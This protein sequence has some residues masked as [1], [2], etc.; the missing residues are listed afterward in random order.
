MKQRKIAANLKKH[1]KKGVTV[2]LQE[3]HRGGVLV[4]RGGE[5][6]WGGGEGVI[7]KGR[8]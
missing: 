3:L 5:W 7:V 8:W 1:S 2:S 6:G 4:G